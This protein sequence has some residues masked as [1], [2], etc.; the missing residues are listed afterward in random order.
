MIGQKKNNN[1]ENTIYRNMQLK[2]LFNILMK[3]YLERF[4][5]NAYDILDGNSSINNIYSNATIEEEYDTDC[6]YYDNLCVD[7]IIKYFSQDG[8]KSIRLEDAKKS[9]TS[10]ESNPT[11][12]EEDT[13][14]QDKEKKK[15][16]GGEIKYK[17]VSGK[18]LCTLI[19]S[20]ISRRTKKTRTTLMITFCI[21]IYFNNLYAKQ[22]S[23]YD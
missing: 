5:A 8:E 3:H 9:F 17:R 22:E 10:T 4:N 20:D 18:V 11:Y 2:E 15:L 1:N 14:Y 7:A 16:F 23:D 13:K 12:Y 6:I 21:H 19:C